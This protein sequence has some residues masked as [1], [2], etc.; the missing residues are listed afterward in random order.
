MKDTRDLS[1]IFAPSSY[2]SLAGDLVMKDSLPG[3]PH[4]YERQQSNNSPNNLPR[5]RMVNASAI[6]DDWP[7]PMHFEDPAERKG[8]CFLQTGAGTCFC[9]S[10]DLHPTNKIRH[11]IV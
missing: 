4:E 10:P 6:V 7:I 9:V 1:G 11:K 3:A 5:Q 8:S 2:M